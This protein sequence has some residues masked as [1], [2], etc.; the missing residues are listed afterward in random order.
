MSLISLLVYLPLQLLFVPLAILGAVLVG[1]KQ[2]VV[3]KR[4]GISQTAIEVINGRW[5]MHIFGLR[6]DAPTAALAAALPNTSTFGLWLALLPLWVKYRLSGSLFLYP[7]VPEPGSEAISDLIVA[8]TLYFDRILE[9]LMGD[10]GQ[11]VL[12]GAGYDTR[13]YGSLRREGVAFF[14]VDQAVV[15]DHKRSS[16]AAAGIDTGDTRFIKVDFARDD[17]FEK[18]ALAGYDPA[19]RT[20][21]LWEGV[22]LYLSEEAVRRNMQ[23]VRDHAAPGSVLLADLYAER[24]IQMGKSKAVAPTL[25]ITGETLSFGLP[26]ASEHEPVLRD[27]VQS[28]S[29]TVGETFFLG[30]K[31]DKGPFSVVVEMVV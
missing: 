30:S 7:R 15:Q 28:E 25:E 5:T 23:A 17:L 16:L 9:R 21:F 27:F 6:R 10:A 26:F 13:A 1:Y 2:L 12:L 24:M 3:S 22:T 18:L 8:R 11:L 20:V 29:L 14:E 4:L 19:V 31:S